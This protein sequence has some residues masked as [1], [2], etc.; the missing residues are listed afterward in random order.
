MIVK[1][2]NQSPSRRFDHEVSRILREE[3][4][5]VTTFSEGGSYYVMGF[6][7]SNLRVH[8]HFGSRVDY[9]AYLGIEPEGN[10]AGYGFRYR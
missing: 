10:D 1:Q 8:A 3:C 6:K 7:D 4:D 5:D 2:T 9:Q